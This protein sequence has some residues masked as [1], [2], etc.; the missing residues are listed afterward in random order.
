MVL[1]LA[2]F[3][4]ETWLGEKKELETDDGIRLSYSFNKGKAPFFVFLHGAGSNRTVF[5]SVLKNFMQHNFVAMDMR[6]HGKST[7][8][9]VSIS[10]HVADLKLILDK[11]N[12]KK[13]IFVGN[14]LGAT[15]IRWFAKKYPANI[16]AMVLIT[17]FSLETTRFSRLLLFLM[18]VI[19][20]IVRQFPS[21]KKLMVQDYSKHEKLPLILFPFVD[22]RGCSSKVYL[23]L[24]IE[25][26]RTTMDF[27]TIRHKTLIITGR[28]D[29]FVN[30][31]L[32]RKK[33]KNNENAVVEVVDST[34]V[35]LI[36]K[37][38]EIAKLIEEFV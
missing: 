25:L 7:G 11:H 31:N 21:R 26:L 22:V 30:T 4:E 16:E 33:T 3:K 9:I 36:K 23:K 10:K 2:G 37:G 24:A 8:K 5:T 6:G 17:P 13:A 28:Y 38:E 35:M 32:I 15:V 12:I 29:Y 27:E 34:H 14:S 19:Y 18:R 1:N 20:G